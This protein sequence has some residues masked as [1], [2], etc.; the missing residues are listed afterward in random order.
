MTTM[1]EKQRVAVEAQE[2]ARREGV[3]LVAYAQAK[4]LVIRELYDALAC[5][6]RKGLLSKPARKI[7][8]RFVSVRVEPGAEAAPT[9]RASGAVLCRIVHRSGYLIECTQWPPP[10]WMRAVM[11][12]SADAAA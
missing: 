2:G 7:A 5:L 12:G 1:T 3:S 10:A 11:A 4:G 8:G 9:V 6:R